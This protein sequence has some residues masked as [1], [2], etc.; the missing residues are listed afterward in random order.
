MVGPEVLIASADGEAEA[1][2]VTRGVFAGF[3]LAAGFEREARENDQNTVDLA[4]L[5][6][7]DGTVDFYRN[8]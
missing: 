3:E 5:D 2:D 1:D 7:P 6:T 4:W 8:D